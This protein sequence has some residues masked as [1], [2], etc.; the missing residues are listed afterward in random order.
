MFQ[1]PLVAT[2]AL[3]RMAARTK[4]TTKAMADDLILRVAV[5]AEAHKLIRPNLNAQSRAPASYIPEGALR[6]CCCPM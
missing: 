3:I 1:P 6:R 5:L 2:S 4:T